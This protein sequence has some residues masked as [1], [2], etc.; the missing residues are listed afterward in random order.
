M[1][2]AQIMPAAAP[3]AAAGGSGGER[4]RGN[5]EDRRRPPAR[6]G[7]AVTTRPKP[8]RGRVREYPFAGSSSCVGLTSSRRV[9]LLRPQPARVRSSR[10]AADLM[11]RVSAPKE[12]VRPAGA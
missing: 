3:T 5:D 10:G 11:P 9:L 2:Q 8:K 7:N 6:P 4:R 1:S 12:E